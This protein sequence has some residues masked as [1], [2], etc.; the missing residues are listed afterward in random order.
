MKRIIGRIVLFL[1]IGGFVFA[2][3]Y[4]GILYHKEKEELANSNKVVKGVV[5]KRRTYL[6]RGSR[7]TVVTVRY[8]VDGKMYKVAYGSYPRLN[9]GD[10]CDVKYQIG[11]PGNSEL[12]E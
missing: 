2:V 7:E 5:V 9:E 11:N 6:H 4:N 8:V 3:T 12:V 10:S 1:L